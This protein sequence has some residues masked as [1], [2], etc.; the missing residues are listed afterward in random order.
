MDLKKH[1]KFLIPLLIL[2]LFSMKTFWGP[3]YFDGHDA[4]AHIVRLQ[5]FD[6]SLKD[7]QFPPR[8]A[9]DLL[10][11]RGYPVFIFT[12]PFAY[13]LAESFHLIGFSLAVSIKLTFI[14]SY[15]LTTFFMY[16]FASTLWKS[17]QAGFLSALLW[18]YAPPIFEKIFIGAAM[19]AVVS[20]IFIPLTLLLILKAIKKPNLKHSSLLAISLALWIHSHI[21]TL[22]IFSPLIALFIISLCYRAKNLVKIIKHLLIGGFLAL[23]LSTWYLVPAFLELKYTHFQDFVF[24]QYPDQFVSLKRLLYSK[25]GTDAPGWGNNPV[26]QQIGIAQ[27]LAAGFAATLLFLKKFKPLSLKLLPFL[28]TFIL[29]VFLML[30]ISQ[31]VWDLVTLIRPVGI[32]WRFLSLAV[33]TSAVSG[34]FLMVVI[35]KP[36]LKNF[37]FIFLI[38]LTLYANRNHLRVNQKILYPDDFFKNYQGVATGWNE[39][40][41]IWVKDYDPT[42]PENKVETMS[43]SC[44]TSDSK[45][46]SNLQTFKADC[47]QE[48]VIQLNT[49]YYP[50]WQLTINHQDVTDQVKQS[51]DQSNGMIRFTLD[52]GK[53]QVTAQFKDTPLRQITKYISL[54]TIGLIAYLLKRK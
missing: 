28:L 3:E 26:S 25:W 4:Q 9:G 45:I 35:K 30:K 21:I 27:W 16:A 32:P 19:G 47:S 36:V 50:G 22:I 44:Q 41:P 8:W 20:F 5:Q 24:D 31:P 53:H 18:S 49:A 15:L 54:L 23:L 1:F 46:K 48:S 13:T 12:Y 14:T 37:I 42:F 2:V 11:G 33:F 40:L 29:S 17:K 6:L 38:A 10:G 7:G 39:H 34:G 43:G 51:L 52:Q